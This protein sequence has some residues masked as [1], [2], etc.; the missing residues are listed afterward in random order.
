MNLVQKADLLLDSVLV[1][2]ADRRIE[3]DEAFFVRQ[4][5]RKLGFREEVVTFLIEYQ[6]MDRSVLHE[7]MIP[8]LIQ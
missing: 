2:M 1:V 5:A 8:Y 4:L 6:T 3:D 7:L